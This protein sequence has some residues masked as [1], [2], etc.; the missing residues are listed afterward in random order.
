L[1]VQFTPYKCARF[2][3]H[4]CEISESSSRYCVN[5][6]ICTGDDLVEGSYKRASENVVPE[7]A[8]PILGKGCALHVDNW[9]SSLMYL[10]LHDML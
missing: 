3:I 4:F 9:C 2:R 7:S 5:S 8:E 1:Y 10:E 6:T